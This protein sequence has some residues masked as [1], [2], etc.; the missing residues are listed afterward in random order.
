[1]TEDFLS[2]NPER[3]AI[4]NGDKRFDTESG[5][6]IYPSLNFLPPTHF[7]Y[8]PCLCA[9][10]CETVCYEHLKKEGKL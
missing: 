7:G 9:K 8:T 2:G 10:S 4:I 1:M 3:D 6:E 5:E